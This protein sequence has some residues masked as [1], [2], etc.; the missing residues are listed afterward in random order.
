MG[1]AAFDN[2]YDWSKLATYRQTAM[3][4]PNG[5]IDLSVGSP[6]DPVPQSVQRALAAA[7]N[8]HNAFGYPRTIGTED[9]KSVV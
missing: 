4:T 7:A 9:R 6:V 3:N 8:E 5:Q 1:F 2:T